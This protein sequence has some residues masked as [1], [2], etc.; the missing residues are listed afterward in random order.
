MT[1]IIALEQVSPAGLDLLRGVEGFEVIEV[2]Q[3][4]P[5]RIRE[6][7]SSAEALLVRS[8]TKVTEA[9]LEQAPLLRVIGRPGTGVDN[10]DMAAATRRGIIVMNTPAGNSVS[11]AEHTFGL[12][13]ALL[14]RIPQA[15]NSL[16]Q[17]KWDRSRFTGVELSGKVL[18]VVGFGKIGTEV[19]RRALA[20]KMQVLVYDPFVP[21]QLAIEQDV[22]LVGL[23]E[24]VAQSDIITLHAPV[25]AA[26]RQIINAATIAKMKDGAWLVNA[27]RGELVDEA[28]LLTALR[29]GKLAGAAL[30]VFVGEPRPNP[31][32]VA[33]P[34]VVATPHLGAS[35]VEAQEKVGYDIAVQIRDYFC[36]GVV[37]NAVNFPS[38]SLSEY[39]RLAPFLELGER[40]G[41]FAG[42]LAE[43]RPQEIT[44]RYYGELAGMNTHLIGSSILVGALRPVL[45]ERVTL[46]NALETA[47]ERAIHFLESRSTRERSFNN[48]ISVKLRTDQ[49]ELWIEGTVLHRRRQHIV[50][51]QGIDVD[52]PLGGRMLVV[53]N[54]DTPGVI[55]R[56]G[57]ILGDNS[58]NIANFALGRREEAR[59]A[60]GLVNVDS[61][62]PAEVIQQIRF[63]RPVKRAAVVSL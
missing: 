40:L 15:C 23:D 32:L 30:D 46:V 20:F 7:L 43:G 22:R 29:E 2:Y 27:A 59:E 47:R 49:G 28:A 38:V 63:L 14:R 44:V 56:V 54:E 33:L 60:V 4:D 53:W 41:S 3:D 19:A 34:N 39:R 26:S 55:G 12:M 48:L 36:E 11:A 35:T 5:E 17:G 42:Q 18:G 6:A 10:V 8:K 50:S 58:I 16:K 31:E 25:T 45:T 21:E 51:L 13:L 62:I 52:A 24:L 57:T 9:L 1:R 61:E 37:N